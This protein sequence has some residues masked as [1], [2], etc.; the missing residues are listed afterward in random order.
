MPKEKTIRLARKEGL[1]L[2]DTGVKG[3]GL[4][5][6][7]PI[8]AGEILEVTPALILNRAATAHVDKTL[9][10]N[11]TFTTGKISKRMREKARLG[12]A[13]QASSVVMGIVSFCNH[14]E[15]PNAEVLWEENAGTLYYSLRATRKIPKNTEICTTYGPEWFSTREDEFPPKTTRKK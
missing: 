10:A 5:C 3:R 11:Y 8:S 6:L 4:F 14:C 12:N 2:K 15:H 7:Y 9:L 13:S 1:Y